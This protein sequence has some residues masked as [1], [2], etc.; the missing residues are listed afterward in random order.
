MPLRDTADVL[1]LGGGHCIRSRPSLHAQSPTSSPSNNCTL[2]YR[3]FVHPSAALGGA[4]RGEFLLWINE[5]LAR[6]FRRDVGGIVHPKLGVVR[7]RHCRLVFNKLL[8]GPCSLR[9][10]FWMFGASCCWECSCCCRK[11]A[12]IGGEPALF[13]DVREGN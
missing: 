8:I 7:E 11:R 3:V 2:T 6:I 5:P 9:W 12:E 4:C 1:A 13:V 10:R